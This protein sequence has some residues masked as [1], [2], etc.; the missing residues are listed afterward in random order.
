M[1]WRVS[2]NT[3]EKP[4][5]PY[6]GKEEMSFAQND[7]VDTSRVFEREDSTIPKL[8]I[9][10]IGS[11]KQLHYKTKSDNLLVQ[12]SMSSPRHSWTMNEMRSPSPKSSFHKLASRRNTGC[13]A[14]FLKAAIIRSIQTSHQS[15]VYSFSDYAHLATDPNEDDDDEMNDIDEGFLLA[16]SVKVFTRNQ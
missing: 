5:T 4:Y 11:A 16:K 14:G 3:S 9:M 13:P 7:S 1:D 12:K 15:M 6:A 10:K 2:N 8:P